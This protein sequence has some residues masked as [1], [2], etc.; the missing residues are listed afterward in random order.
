MKIFVVILSPTRY[1]NILNRPRYGLMRF[2]GERGSLS[3][4]H[5]TT[6]NT[7]YVTPR[8]TTQTAVTT[9]V[10][11][12]WYESSAPSASRSKADR[13]TRCLT[14]WSSEMSEVISFSSVSV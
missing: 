6:Y 14:V 8:R 7:N 4:R 10:E 12:I 9:A 2:A 1:P 5:S 13:L 11:L 3:L